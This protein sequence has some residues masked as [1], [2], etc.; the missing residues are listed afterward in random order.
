MDLLDTKIKELSGYLLISEKNNIF[1]IKNYYFF[2][3]PVSTFDY[4]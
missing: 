2:V 1:F 4:P 3:N